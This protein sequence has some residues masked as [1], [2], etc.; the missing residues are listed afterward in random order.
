MIS[1]IASPPSSSL[2]APIGAHGG[3]VAGRN[4][5]GWVA[6]L[7]VAQLLLSLDMPAL[8]GRPWAVFWALLGRIVSGDFTMR[9][10]EVS[11]WTMRRG[12]ERVECIRIRVG[13]DDAGAEGRSYFELTIRMIYVETAVFHLGGCD[14]WPVRRFITLVSRISAKIEIRNEH[15]HALFVTISK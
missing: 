1:R 3:A 12:L 11:Q 9:G 4:A 7:W 10:C 6:V 2:I 15:W 13:G 14:S 5:V 8:Q